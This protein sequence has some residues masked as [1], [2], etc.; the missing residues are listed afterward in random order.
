MLPCMYSWPL[1]CILVC[2]RTQ[3]LHLIHAIRYPDWSLA[4]VDEL[5][6]EQHVVCSGELSHD[7]DDAVGA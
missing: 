7:A 2:T 5:P 3:C 1:S 6:V 4:H